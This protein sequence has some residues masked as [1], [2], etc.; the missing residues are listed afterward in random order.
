MQRPIGLIGAMAEEIALFLEE[1]EIEATRELADIT[2]TT[3]RLNETEVVVCQS[4]VGKVNAAVCTQNLIREY[5]VEAVIFT[6]VAGALDPSLDIGD[7]VVSTACQQHDVDA[8]ALGLPK[9]TIPFQ[10]T[11][12]FKADRKWIRLA[13]EAAAGWT[14]GKVLKGKI[15]SGDQF[16]ANADAVRAL[17]DSLGGVCVE[18]EGAAVAHVCHLHRIPYVVIRSMSDRADHSAD[19][20]FADF[21]V[22]SARR[23]NGIVQ[24]ML[25][26]R[27]AK[28]AQ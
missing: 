14:G 4:G 13:E 10:E 18:M 9:G 2:Y 8:T 24:E 1:M 27:Q 5:G 22:A 20:N 7:I 11:S 6:G 15:L 16:I 21:A 12:I 25:N 23:S 26:R 3:G 17:R 28:S 19:I